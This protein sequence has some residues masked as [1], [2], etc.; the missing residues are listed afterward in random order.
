MTFVYC[1]LSFA[2]GVAGTLVY[3]AKIVNELNILK[4]KA[5]ADLAA[6]K[7]KVASKL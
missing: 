6:L 1:L 2:V 4:L 7:A 5:E 3:H